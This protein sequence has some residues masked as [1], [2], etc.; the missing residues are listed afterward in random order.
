MAERYI[1]VARFMTTN[2]KPADLA[3]TSSEMRV[4]QFI[5]EVEG[6]DDLIRVTKALVVEEIT[7]PALR[8]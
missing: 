7:G 3:V 4:D 6:R 2:G 8:D 5:R 1:A